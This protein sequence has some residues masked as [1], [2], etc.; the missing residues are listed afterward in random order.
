MKKAIRYLRFSS[1]DQSQH[2]IERQ[3][4]VTTAWMNQQ[5][6][7]LVDTFTDE[8]FSAR[9][10]DRPDIK[11][12][13]EFIKK[14]FRNIDYLVVSELTRFS[15]DAG[16]A[17]STLKEIQKKYNIRIVSAGT[18]RIYDFNDSSSY[19]LMGIEFLLGT[20]ENIKR[21][22]DINGGIYTAKAIK[23]KWVQGGPAPYGYKKDGAADQRRLIVNEEEAT[24]IRYIFD[25]YLKDVPVYIIRKEVIQMGFRRKGSS[26]IQEVLKS[27]LYI[28]HQIVK[29]WDNKPGGLFPIKD[30]QEVIDKITWQKVQEK[31]SGPKYKKTI[32]DELPLR[33]LLRCQCS[34]RL[35][36][37]Y[38][39]NP[40]K[41]KY[42][43]YKCSA[44][45]H[46]N[47]SASTAHD[48]L[49]QMLKLL[50]LPS[51]MIDAIKE[52]TG[53]QMIEKHSDNR[54]QLVQA[55]KDLAKIEE[56]ILTV[57]KKFLS[58]HT[59]NTETY[60]RW[61]HQLSKQR[62]EVAAR[63]EKF[64]RDE[65]AAWLLISEDLNKLSD[66]QY[67]YNSI[68]T[69][70]KQELLRQVFDDCLYY[71]N[72][73]YRTPWI[74]ETFSHNLLELREKSLLIIDEPN[75]YNQESPVMWTPPSH[76]RTL[77]DFLSFISNLKAA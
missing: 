35:T 70:D 11:L 28:S 52:E 22:T 77:P 68:G 54:K 49:Q 27:P 13:F 33:G 67:L 17:L 50:S 26:A 64:S 56:D 74:M 19:F 18:N 44:S 5:N 43:F 4:L 57:E 39:T 31:I 8:G 16:E 55:K 75:Y 47:L 51:Y 37:A 58:E 73:S 53:K 3:D 20:T 23:G 12:L 48:Q 41:K 1:D 66:L 6:I 24:V 38:S 45:K 29:A 34:K 36:G 10:F 9:T 32:V 2:S 30:L 15:R 76:N 65:H 72:N 61:H 62:I 21:T 71:K 40:L 63:I 14:N 42:P 46:L 59:I 7:F 69:T 25:Q 60:Q